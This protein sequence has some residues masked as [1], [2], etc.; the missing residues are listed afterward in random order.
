MKRILYIPIEVQRRECKAKLY[1]ACK[2]LEA[3]H[4]VVIGR[5]WQ[6][7]RFALRNYNGIYL[8]K[9][10]F[11]NAFPKFELLK[12]RNFQII[13]HDEEGST[14]G[15]T[16]EEYVNQRV[17]KRTLEICDNILA[18]G[19]LEEGYLKRYAPQLSEKI[20]VAGNPRLD[21]LRN[22]SY[23]LYEKEIEK[24]HQKIGKYILVN[25]AFGHTEEATA[26]IREEYKDN[27][28]ATSD[29]Q[30]YITACKIVKEPF[31]DGIC[32]LA[33]KLDSTIVL[34]PHPAENIEEYKY[35]F[36]PYP[37]VYITNS[38][39]VNP[40]IWGASAVIYNSCT[41]GMESFIT[42]I[43]TIAYL[44][45]GKSIFEDVWFNKLGYMI[46]TKEELLDEIERILSQNIRPGEIERQY[47][48][49]DKWKAL[50]EVIFY[51]KWE[52]SSDKFIR[53]LWNDDVTDG[54]NMMRTC[55]KFKGL[56]LPMRYLLDWYFYLVRDKYR[57]YKWTSLSHKKL[58]ENVNEINRVLQLD[59]SIKV[60]PLL[61][62]VYMLKAE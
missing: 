59:L 43:P 20:K 53:C 8:S 2:A 5:H 23:G 49:Q 47:F 17:G 44:P 31:V 22:E 62:D 18:W 57:D 45:E 40:W 10:H 4:D 25:T 33:D 56:E 38:L 35:M 13:A 51:D 15:H 52:S 37:N 32:Y 30:N 34:R 42:G 27:E 24:I 3:G 60:I 46:T 1:L 7:E 48:S 29:I 12:Q 28:A 11:E 6:V 50:D 19:K 41:T 55:C 39:G 9:S 21:L 61:K 14:T 58:L 26:K 36:R 54:Y 16:Y